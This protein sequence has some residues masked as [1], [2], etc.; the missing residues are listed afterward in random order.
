M[1]LQL[2]R[3]FWFPLATFAFVGVQ[4]KYVGLVFT[5]TTRWI[6][7][8]LLLGHLVI[9]RRFLMGL[10]SAFGVSLLAYCIWCMLTSIWSEVPELSVAKSTA[11]VLVSLTFVSAGYFWI[12]KRDKLNAIRYLVP[13]ATLA[14]FAG[15]MGNNAA[16]IGANLKIYGGLT[17]P[18]ALGAMIVMSLP[19]LLWIA[20]KERKKPLA[21]WIWI[22][23]V[24]VALAVLMRSGSRA[25]TLGA[26]IVL[27]LF[28]MSLKIRVT[29]FYSLL[30]MG[31]L[32][33]AASVDAEL[34]HA[35]YH[36]YLLK[37]Q[38]EK[39]GILFS[40]ERVWDKSYENAIA[41][42]WFG[43]GY[44]VTIG[45]TVFEGGLTAETYGRE[46]GNAQL[47]IVEETG[48]IGLLLYFGLLLTLFT[49]ILSAF[50]REKHGDMKVILGL[51][52]GAL[53]GITFTSVFEAWWVAPGSAES[54][55]FWGLAGVGLGLAERSRR[56]SRFLS[57]STAASRPP[58]I[59]AVRE[60]GAR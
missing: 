58:L 10:N 16:T 2:L 37:G 11:F 52:M 53:C 18:N 19:V 38:T 51:I 29:V 54:A 36:D 27:I 4:V 46:K 35:T 49:R 56:M 44:G 25:S 24:A 59:R 55:F 9:R 50:I 28:L 13:V 12:E 31:A 22:A 1:I 32:L 43:A 33:I 23:L 42:G 21:R 6:F 3:N 20:Y 26:A 15:I 48:K 47:A 14:L 34:I 60:Q 45:D 57:P 30:I 40:R 41:G 8:L 5:P 39:K 7:L 17:H